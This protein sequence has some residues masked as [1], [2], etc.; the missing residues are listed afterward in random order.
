LSTPAA[1]SDLALRHRCPTCEPATAEL[2]LGFT[3]TVKQTLGPPKIANF[4]TVGYAELRNRYFLGG[5]PLSELR[6][7][8]QP[9]QRKAPTSG[10]FL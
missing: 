5:F 8:R 3:S 2:F 4:E 9:C 10:A 7:I 6:L 1:A